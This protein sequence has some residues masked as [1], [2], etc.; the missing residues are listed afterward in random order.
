MGKNRRVVKAANA[1]NRNKAKL[2]KHANNNFAAQMADVK[3]GIAHELREKDKEMAI[4]RDEKK[5]AAAERAGKRRWIAR[6]EGE[7]HAVKAAQEVKW[8]HEVTRKNR[9]Q[10]VKTERVHTARGEYNKKAKA[11]VVKK[12]SARARHEKEM[13]EKAAQ[14]ANFKKIEKKRKE[15]GIKQAVPEKQKK[16][17][18]ATFARD[19]SSKRHGELKKKNDALR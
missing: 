4:W 19:A 7:E 9:E 2:E 16:I 12:N 14:I 1:E 11:E 3:A 8:N 17:D 15:K 5:T 6:K 13:S 10:E 18:E